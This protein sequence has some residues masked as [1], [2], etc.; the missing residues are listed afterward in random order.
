MMG[1]A[2]PSAGSR[3]PRAR[4]C[5]DGGRAGD[6]A[7]EAARAGARRAARLA[8]AHGRPRLRPPDRGD[9]LLRA[10]IPLARPPP[11]TRSSRSPT[12]RSPGWDLSSGSRPTSS[13]AASRTARPGAGRSAPGRPGRPDPLEPRPRILGEPGPRRGDHPRDGRRARR[14]VLLRLPADRAGLEA[15][16]LRERVA[17]ALGADGRPR[18]VRRPHLARTR[19]SPPRSCSGR[20]CAA[21]ASTWPAERAPASSTADDAAARIARVAAARAI[22]SLDG[23][24]ER[25]LHGRA[26]A[27]AARDRSRQPGTTAAGAAYVGADARGSGDPARRRAA[28]RR[29]RA[30]SARPPDGARARRH[31]AGRLG[32]PRRP[33]LLLRR[34]AG[35]RQ[36]RHALRPDAP[37]AR[38]RA[39]PRARPATTQPASALSGYVKRRYVFSVVQNGSPVSWTWARRAQDRFATALAGA[40]ASSARPRRA[41]A[42]RAARPSR[43]STPGSRRRRRRSS[44]SRPSPPT[45]APFASSALRAS[46]R[47]KPSSVP[48]IT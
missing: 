28:R 25:Q 40:V 31:P 6:A 38:A 47:L 8:S 29:L 42:R 11:R 33:A 14:R 22:V 10:R 30:L 44:S 7:R 21:P 15:L 19:R 26:A 35:G 13:G 37:A 18:P 24:R 17:A 39:R 41:P 16:V 23:P 1:R 2:T 20:R 45:F 12:Q 43:P 34:P 36:E 48:V 46:S 5:L 4:P 9:A 27:Q 3:P 32:R